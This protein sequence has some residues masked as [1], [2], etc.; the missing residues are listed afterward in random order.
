V[1]DHLRGLA[2]RGAITT[3]VGKVYGFDDVPRMIAE[4][5]APGAGKTVV[6]VA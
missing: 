1:W 2:E 3:P 4:Q 5:M 6:R